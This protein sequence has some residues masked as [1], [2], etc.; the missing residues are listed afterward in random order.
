MGS[1]Y[2]VGAFEF[3][4]QFSDSVVTRQSFIQYV[5]IKR[6]AIT[7]EGREV[8]YY[9][10]NFAEAFANVRGLS[11][12]DTHS[13]VTELEDW[14]R[15]A[16]VKV[17]VSCLVGPGFFKG[18]GVPPGG[19][20]KKWAKGNTKDIRW[21]TEPSFYKTV[22]TFTKKGEDDID[23]RS[24]GAIG[25]AGVSPDTQTRNVQALFLHFGIAEHQE[26]RKMDD[27]EEINKKP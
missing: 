9:D 20:Y 2:T 27:T 8:L 18:E 4:T 26:F 7:P 6:W 14:S 22:Y 12:V 23:M 15:Y 24:G 17:E 25:G 1:K 5:S 10:E 19:N 11:P 16:K 3:Y 21:S 13:S